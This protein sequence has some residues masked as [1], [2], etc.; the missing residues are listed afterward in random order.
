MSD[1]DD[2]GK[3]ESFGRKLFFVVLDKLVLAV[4]IVLVSY[5]F[6]QAL[7]KQQMITEYQKSLFEKRLN[8]YEDLLKSAKAARDECAGFYFSK[9]RSEEEAWRSR[10][11]FIEQRAFDL[12]HGPSGGGGGGGDI[13]SESYKS[14]A[15]ALQKVEDARRANGLYMSESV[16]HKVDEFL[17]TVLSALDTTLQRAEKKQPYDPALEHAAMYKSNQAYEDL[18][19]AIMESLR[20]KEIILG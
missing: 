3:P 16:N 19:S 18:R 1:D 2:D 4:A 20:L 5:W 17:N 15:K 12:Q 6:T 8:A 11:A 13:G 7:Q 14:V 10:F 9:E